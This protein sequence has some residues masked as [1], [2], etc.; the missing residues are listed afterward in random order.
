MPLF[1]RT[2]SLIRN[3][4]RRDR[5]DRNIHEELRSYL[6]LLTEEKIASGI[7]PTEARRQ[8]RIELGGLEQVKENIRDVRSGAFLDSAAQDIRFALRTLRRAPAFT[9][10]AILTLALGIGATTAIFSIVNAVLLKPLPIR[11]PNRVV[12]LHDQFF[13]FD[14]PRTKV[15]P[16]QFREFSQH[17]EI[18]RSTAA[19][20]PAD[21]TLTSSDRTQH[22]QAMKVTSG[23]FPLLGVEPLRGRLFTQADD[24][25]GNPHVVLLGDALWENLFDRDPKAIG[26]TLRLDGS[27]YEIIGVIPSKLDAMFFPHPD[28]WIPAAIDPESATE[29]IAGTSTTPCWR[30]FAPAS[31]STRRARRCELPWPNSTMPILSLESKFAR[32]RKKNPETCASRSTSCSAPYFSSC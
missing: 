27:A 28:V 31:H 11:E 8:A 6:D 12:A 30:D 20:K 25:L 15:S 5:A 21:L 18:F 23:Y 22:I 32:S 4:F 16:L 19:F 26:K 2:S 1:P 10:I 9:A 24:T 17:T 7:N 29:N 3:L 13:S 14:N